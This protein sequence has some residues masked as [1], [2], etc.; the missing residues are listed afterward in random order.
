MGLS[1]WMGTRVVL[2][3]GSSDFMEKI[4]FSHVL[5]P[6]LPGSC[7]LNLAYSVSIPRRD[8]FISNKFVAFSDFRMLPIA[9]IQSSS[10]SAP[11]AVKADKHVHKIEL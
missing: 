10:C 9:T 3:T 8:T 1:G 7:Q 5:G 6:Q 2:R 4:R 11:G